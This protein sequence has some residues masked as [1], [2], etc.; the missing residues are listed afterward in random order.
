[1]HTQLGSSCRR[2]CMD[3]SR[4]CYLDGLCLCVLLHCASRW[5]NR[6][7]IHILHWICPDLSHSLISCG[8]L[9]WFFHLLKIVG[10]G[11]WFRSISGDSLELISWRFLEIF[12]IHLN[13]Q[14]KFL[15]TP[16][17][18]HDYALMSFDIAFSCFL[19]W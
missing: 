3:L 14:M 11:P 12:H 2:I 5:N 18:K 6:H 19:F 4:N 1:M 9:I 16:Y 7:S 15:V 8:G 10:N 13:V 17:W